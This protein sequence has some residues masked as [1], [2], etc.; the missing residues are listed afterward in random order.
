[1]CSLFLYCFS[2]IQFFLFYLWTSL[3]TT[4]TEWQPDCR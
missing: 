2:C 4:A 3:Q 1:V